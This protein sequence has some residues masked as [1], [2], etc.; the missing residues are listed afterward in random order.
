ML[1]PPRRANERQ[2]RNLD[3]TH[4]VPGGWFWPTYLTEPPPFVPVNV[5][6]QRKERDTD[7]GAKGLGCMAVVMGRVVWVVKRGEL[8][9]EFAAY[10]AL[11]E[12]VRP[13]RCGA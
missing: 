12:R 7:V 6:Q 10:G 4:G 8:E 9:R 11:P 1:R 13:Y 3:G 2:K 5:R